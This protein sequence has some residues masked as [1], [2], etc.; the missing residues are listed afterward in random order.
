MTAN[1]MLGMP[2]WVPNDSL[3]RCKKEKGYHLPRL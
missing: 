2:I 1:T 3:A